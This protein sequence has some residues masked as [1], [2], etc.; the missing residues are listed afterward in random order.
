MSNTEARR[1]RCLSNQ[2]SKSEEKTFIMQLLKDP[3]ASDII[4]ESL[5]HYFI[6]DQT[7][8]KNANKLINDNQ[9]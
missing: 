2:L 8:A 5:F 1:F 7:K 6:H 4:T 9:K 3:A